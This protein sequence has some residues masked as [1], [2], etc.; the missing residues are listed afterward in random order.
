MSFRLVLVTTAVLAV[1]AGT[2][3][4]AAAPPA[5]V[6]AAIN[7]G[8]GAGVPAA[9]SSS[10]WVP[11][12]KLGSVARV[13]IASNRV[14]ARI[15]LG[16]PP[17]FTGYLDAAI[18]AGGSVWI[19]RDV[20]DELDRIDPETNKLVARIKVDSRP[21]GLAAGGGYVWAFHFLG[22]YLTRIDASTGAKRVFTINGAAGTGIA[23]DRG[24]VWLLTAN[25]SSVIKIDPASGKVLA[26]IALKPPQPPK[27]GIVDTWWMAAGGGS[28]WVAI[29][30]YDQAA[31]VDE[32]TAKVKAYVPVP[33]QIPFG[34]AVYKGSAWIAGEAKVVR[35]DPATN[36][37]TGLVTLSRSR[38]VFTQVAAGPSGLWATDYDTGK[39]YRLGVS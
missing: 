1:C 36:T 23:V 25:P 16:E 2:L 3:A 35:I 29:A 11:L 8:R 30:N 39:L 21:G 17:R 37:V 27:H 6:V 38:A 18:L 31:R 22:P 7:V 14:V 34:A 19:A 28:L 13:D 9:D 15:K 10:V 24:A 5:T 26:R 20:G 4:G 33:V 32:A 12:T